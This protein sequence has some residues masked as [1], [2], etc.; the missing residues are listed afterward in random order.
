MTAC[1]PCWG[2]RLHVR[3]RRL[4]EHEARA[5][6]DRHHR[7]PL[8]LGD[9]ERGFV[10]VPL[11]RGAMHEDRNRAERLRGGALEQLA[12]GGRLC[13]IR[14]DEAGIE[15]ARQGLPRFD[16]VMSLSTRPAPSAGQSLR[17]APPDA[18][19]RSGH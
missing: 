1:V 6:S 12:G 18:G 9:G 10:L 7:I 16:I 17:H 2:A 11:R 15:F 13:Q 4:T 8:R 3:A 19:C 5:Q 14:R